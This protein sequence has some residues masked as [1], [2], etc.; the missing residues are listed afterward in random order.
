MSK[1]IEVRTLGLCPGRGN[2]ARADGSIRAV[3][4]QGIGKDLSPAHAA[5]L[6]SPCRARAVIAS[7]PSTAEEN[8]PNESPEIDKR[9]VLDVPNTVA[10]TASMAAALVGNSPM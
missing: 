2:L 8:V 3:S 9:K 1:R 10:L 5:P 6:R 7:A 4:E